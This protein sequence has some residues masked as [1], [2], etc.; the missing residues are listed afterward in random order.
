[1]SIVCVCVFSSNYVPHNYISEIKVFLKQNL[2]KDNIK[3]M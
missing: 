1:M 3:C 2:D